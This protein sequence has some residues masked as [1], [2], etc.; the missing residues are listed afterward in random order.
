MFQTILASIEDNL[1]AIIIGLPLLFAPILA[2]ISTKTE[3]SRYFAWLG[4][5]LVTG[6]MV[7]ASGFQLIQVEMYG[8]NS[9]DFGSW[10]RNVGIE[11]LADNFNAMLIFF[12]AAIAFVTMPYALTSVEKEI[13]KVR[14]PTFYA[15]FLLCLAGLIGM[16]STN[17]LFNFF[18]FLEVSSLT[19]YAMVALGKDKKALL[20]AFN[21]LIIGAIGA[22]LYLL[23]VMFLYAQTG[24][25]NFGEIAQSLAGLEMNKLSLAAFIF[26]AVGLMIKAGVHPLASWLP[27]AYAEAPSFVSGFMSGT[28]TKVALFAFIKILFTLFGAQI[29]FEEIGFDIVLKFI[30]LFAMFYGSIAA[31]YQTDVKRL[32]AY[33]SIANVGYI[34]LGVALANQAGLTS[35]IFNLVAHGLAKTG[36]FLAIGILVMQAGGSSFK[37]LGG[38]G[39]K[40]P[41]TM[42]LFIIF[43]LSL[44]GTPLTAGFI[45]KWY[46]LS[47]SM[48]SEFAF[49]FVLS[50]LL[51]S[52]L[53]VVYIWRV[54]EMAYF[55]DLSA[56]M[57]RRKILQD[58][59][60]YSLAPLWLLAAAVIY[61]GV[62]PSGLLSLANNVAGGL[63]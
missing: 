36:A 9:Y 39:K 26:I 2:I 35:A 63:L 12:V 21:Y 3:N 61:F 55:S 24:S 38:L 34:I 18:V 15:C 59:D 52:I 43:G 60:S 22:T 53:A 29:I 10:P 42:F 50:V 1:P 44:I 54:V 11:H 62:Y 33:S 8:A 32:L 19:S 51:S 57:K 20:A 13:S 49:M 5:F 7:A 56:N 17:D 47:A 4:C 16:L 58:P 48:Q 41:F 37:H 27:A 14:I 30:A 45:A 25:L 46:L 28:A 40:M 31:I 23:G 6:L